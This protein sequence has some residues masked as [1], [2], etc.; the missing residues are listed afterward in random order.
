[1]EQHAEILIGKPWTWRPLGWRDVM[2]ALLVV[3]VIVLL[4]LGGQRMV[5]PFAA[6]QR[7]NISLS[8]WVLPEYALRSTMR[9]LAALLASLVFTFTYATAAA[10]S[11]GWKWS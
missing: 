1:M 10:K 9:M 3:A 11:R 7:P 2:A 6:T 5:A 8:P 4:G